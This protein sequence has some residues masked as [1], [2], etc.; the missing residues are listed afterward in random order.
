MY[1]SR[2]FLLVIVLTVPLAALAQ[3]SAE[4]TPGAR[5]RLYI[6]PGGT[7]RIGF[8]KRITADTL[9]L[10]T[11][12]R[13][14]VEAVPYAAIQH[15]EISIG[16]GGYP[17][18]GAAIGALVGAVIGAF[19]IAPCPGGTPGSDLTSCGFSRTMGALT[20]TL[21]GVFA[22]GALGRW[23]PKERWRPARVVSAFTLRGGLTN[24]AA[25][26]GRYSIAHPSR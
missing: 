19:V 2:A 18:R 11:C 15:A 13:C 4:I 23:W 20:G 17:L 1:I 16:R 7:E 6:A 5:A 24:V 9:F 3:D 21:V 8:V 14:E 22:G 25:E 26:L 12:G 10:R